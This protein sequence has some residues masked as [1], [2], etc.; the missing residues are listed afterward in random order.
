MEGKPGTYM[1]VA[2]GATAVRAPRTVTRTAARTGG[3]PEARS[4]AVPP[5][6]PPS[7]RGAQE[8]EGDGDIMNA[9]VTD[10]SPVNENAE[11]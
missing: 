6:V 9:K 1:S 5:S 2:S 8:R 10:G 11:E 4:P 3:G 7:A